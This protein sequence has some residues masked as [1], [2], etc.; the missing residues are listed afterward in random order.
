MALENPLTS[1]ND[2]YFASINALPS[3]QIMGK[4]QAYQL[5]ASSENYLLDLF[6]H[7]SSLHSSQTTREVGGVGSLRLH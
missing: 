3:K 5:Q 2:F 6:F 1:K 4:L 7:R